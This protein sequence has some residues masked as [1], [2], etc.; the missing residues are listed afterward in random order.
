M[1]TRRAARADGFTLLEVLVALAILAVA[2]SGAL[3]ALGNGAQSA[4]A[5]REHM[6]ARWVAQDRLARLRAEQAW[7]PVGRS[8]GV[9]EQAGRRYR[10][11]QTTRGTP[12]PLFRQVEVEVLP[13]DEERVLL[14]LHGFAVLP[15]R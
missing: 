12:N 8:E 2:L 13:A 14:S 5:L 15:L 4:E 9:A 3:R 6:L 11:R 1:S 10:W 7:P